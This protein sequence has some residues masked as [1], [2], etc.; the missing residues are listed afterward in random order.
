MGYS[1]NEDGSV[2]RFRRSKPTNSQNSNGGG[3][4]AL[5][6]IIAIIAI[7]ALILYGMDMYDENSYISTNPANVEC[8]YKGG[9][10]VINVHSNRKWKISTYTNNWC[11]L[12]QGSETVR[13]YIDE[14]Y[15]SEPRQDYFTLEANGSFCQVNIRQKGRPYLRLSSTQLSMSG[16]GGY[17]NISVTSS[18]SWQVTDKPA[19]WVHISTYGGGLSVSVDENPYTSSRSTSFVVQTETNKEKVFISQSATAYYLNISAR[20]PEFEEDGGRQTI[21]IDSYPDWYISS[22]PNQNWIGVQKNGRNLIIGCNANNGDYKREAR[23]KI[24]ANNFEETI[25]VT[26]WGKNQWERITRGR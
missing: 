5:W 9:N 17:T 11:H 23:I 6:I 3:H 12:N 20:F 2:T 1:V 18:E 16:N 13:L 7:G 25:Y 24:R 8:N 15:S 4:S 10:I 22:Y 26:Q 19:S 14:N 21:T